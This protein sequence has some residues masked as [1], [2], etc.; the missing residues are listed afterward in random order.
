MELYPDRRNDGASQPFV[1]IKGKNINSEKQ[2]SYYQ[3]TLILVC[4]IFSL[5]EMSNRLH[6]IR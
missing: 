6:K 1:V 2:R 5:W 3:T 4:I